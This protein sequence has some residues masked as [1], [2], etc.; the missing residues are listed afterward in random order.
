LRYTEHNRRPLLQIFS[1]CFKRSNDRN[2]PVNIER[3]RQRNIRQLIN[4]LKE[5]MESQDTSK[6]TIALNL[7][8]EEARKL[9]NF[10]T[11]LGECQICFRYIENKYRLQCKHFFC[12]ECLR[13]MILESTDG[14]KFECPE[15]VEIKKRYS[16]KDRENIRSELYLIDLINL[17]SQQELNDICNRQTQPFIDNPKNIGKYKRCPTIGCPNILVKKLPGVNINDHVLAVKKRCGTLKNTD[18]NS[19]DEKMIKEKGVFANIQHSDK[20][21][22]VALAKQ[23]DEDNDVLNSS[24]SLDGEGNDKTMDINYDND[25]QIVFC[26]VCGHDFCFKCCKNHYGEDCDTHD[27]QVDRCLL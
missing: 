21:K 24:V 15:C 1:N 20:A 6:S 19:D 13:G 14:T 12:V 9:C 5:M 22:A 23:Q 26:E 10:Y 25:R 11:N 2:T 16:P 17:L 8:D 27:S 18:L 4:H 7:L 3:N